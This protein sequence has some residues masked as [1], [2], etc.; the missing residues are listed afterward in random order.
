MIKFVFTF[1]LMYTSSL[2]NLLTI[3]ILYLDVENL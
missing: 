3:F 1:E 2:M